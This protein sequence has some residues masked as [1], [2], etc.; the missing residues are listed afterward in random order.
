[1]DLLETVRVLMMELLLLSKVVPQI[2]I[3]VSLISQR[4]FL[5]LLV[6]I[7]HHV[8]HESPLFSQLFLTSPR[9]QTFYLCYSL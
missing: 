5:L 2:I 9:L 8:S 6:H 3:L 4:L 7:L 1:M